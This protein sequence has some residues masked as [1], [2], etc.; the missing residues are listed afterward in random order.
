LN[1]EFLS[2]IA[3]PGLSIIRAGAPIAT[4][5]RKHTNKQYSDAYRT[6]YQQGYG[7]RD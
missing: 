3:H 5:I 7:G 4:A 1:S 6:G 2:Y